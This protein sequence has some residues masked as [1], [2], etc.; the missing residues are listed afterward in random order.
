VSHEPTIALFATGGVMLGAEDGTLRFGVGASP[1]APVSRPPAALSA[2]PEY[3]RYEGR[4]TSCRT[5][6]WIMKPIDQDS[7]ETA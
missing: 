5:A 7:R 2:R 1:H 3:A 6:A 4:P